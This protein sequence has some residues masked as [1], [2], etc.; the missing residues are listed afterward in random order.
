MLATTLVRSLCLT[1]RSPNP[2][3]SQ[4]W[5]GKE[6]AS[7]GFLL[8]VVLASYATDKINKSYQLD[9]TMKINEIAPRRLDEVTLPPWISKGVQPV[10]KYA[11]P[12]VNKAVQAASSA[13]KP[14]IAMQPGETMD[15]AIAR[16]K[17][18]APA[19]ADP[20]VSNAEMQA[21]G[22]L[23]PEKSGLSS[24]FKRRGDTGFDPDL[25]KT[26]ALPDYLQNMPPASIGSLPKPKPRPDT[27]AA[28]RE[29][30]ARHDMNPRMPNKGKPSA[31][32]DAFAAEK[33]ARAEKQAAE[34]LAAAEKQAAAERQASELPADFEPPMSA[35]APEPAP[36]ATG[37]R[38]LRPRRPG[39]GS[40][41]RA[42]PE[43]AADT[44]TLPRDMADRL[45]R[46]AERD[47]AAAQEVAK[48]MGLPAKLFLGAAG[49]GALAAA[50]SAI[51][52]VRPGTVPDYY[53]PVSIVTQGPEKV[54]APKPLPPDRAGPAV[55]EI[56]TDWSPPTP[57]ASTEKPAPTPAA[58]TETP[59][60]STAD[61]TSAA[62]GDAAIA[63]R[64]KEL[65]KQKVDESTAALNRMVYLSRL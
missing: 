48:K 16:I 11:E 65:L 37:G 32:A 42:A 60:A 34:E 29:V 1:F 28:D 62:D 9:T 64:V 51:N 22:V 35:N 57:A 61:S 45:L 27:S 3:I 10:V 2:R 40:G 63:A 24:F 31:E 38:Q 39:Q 54:F 17:A 44:V 26:Q 18:A 14:R 5:E 7:A 13:M 46:M 53:N 33:A 43:P 15:Q 19:S 41:Q 59:A 20:L 55:K 58:S 52:A 49:V 8:A 23:P 50:P 47:P 21:L 6:P 30:R 12:Y 56:L 25:N 4:G 36:A